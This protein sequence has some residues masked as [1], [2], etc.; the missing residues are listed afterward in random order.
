MQLHAVVYGERNNPAVAH[1][2]GHPALRRVH[3]DGLASAI[4]RVGSNVGPVAA[5]QFEPALIS[6]THHRRQQH[7]IAQHEHVC[8]LFGLRIAG[9]LH[10]QRPDQR[11]AAIVSLAQIGGQIWRPGL[12]RRRID[13]AFPGA[14]I[15][16][17]QKRAQI[18][19]ARFKLARRSVENT[20]VE[21]RI[22]NRGQAPLIDRFYKRREGVPAIARPYSEAWPLVWA[23]DP[24][25][26]NRARRPSL[27]PEDE[28]SR[29]AP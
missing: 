7:F 17:R 24:P 21:R 28:A 14:A 16:D 6:G 13:S 27:H 29:A 9:K 22:Q 19:G 10:R 20:Q 4:L 15:Q 1:E 23:G 2:H 12:P 11:I 3:L 8:L 5:R 26:P 18:R 25:S